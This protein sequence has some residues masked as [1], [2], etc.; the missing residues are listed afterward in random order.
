MSIQRRNLNLRST[1]S[2][3]TVTTRVSGRYSLPRSTVNVYRP[4]G[5]ETTNGWAESVVCISTERGLSVRCL[6]YSTAEPVFASDFGKCHVPSS[7]SM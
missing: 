6:R 2:L 5:S 3:P 1:G 7:P 4:G